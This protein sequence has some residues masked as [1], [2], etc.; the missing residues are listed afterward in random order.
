MNIPYI[1]LNSHLSLFNGEGGWGTAY[2]STYLPIATGTGS[3]NVS[4]TVYGSIH[5]VELVTPTINF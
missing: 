5:D 2:V 1:S 3:S 4:Y